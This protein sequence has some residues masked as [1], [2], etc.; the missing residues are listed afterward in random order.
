MCYFHENFCIGS[1]GYDYSEVLSENAKKSG[2]SEKSQVWNLGSLIV[3][4]SKHLKDA[5]IGKQMLK[6][7]CMLYMSNLLTLHLYIFPSS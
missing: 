5:L 6:Q 1:T 2:G 3:P 4:L 7:N